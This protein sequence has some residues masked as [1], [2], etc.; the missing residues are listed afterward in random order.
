LFEE[1]VPTPTITIPWGSSFIGESDRNYVL[2]YNEYYSKGTVN[3]SVEVEAVSYP[4]YDS[5]EWNFDA[6]GTLK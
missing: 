6:E 4:N 2:L 5:E 1:V 3:S